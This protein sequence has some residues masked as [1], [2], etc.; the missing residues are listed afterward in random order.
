M[1]ITVIAAAVSIALVGLSAADETRAAIRKPLNIPEQQLGP[2]L[3]AL[4]KDRNLQVLF[5]S[6]LVRDVR[7]AGAIGELTTDEALA[8]LL[9]GTVLTFQYLDEKTITIVPLRDSGPARDDSA[10][11]GAVISRPAGSAPAGARTSSELP[12]AERKPFWERFRL[13]QANDG[14]T[15][16]STAARRDS[17]QEAKELEAITVTGSR[18]RGAVTPS[19]LITIDAQQ[20]REE[21]FTDLG[22][23]IRSVPQNFNGGQNPGVI[24][25]EATNPANSNVT[26]GSSLNLR[27]LGTDATL[28]LLNGQRMSYGGFYPAVD[29]SAIPVEAVERIEIVADGASAIY[30]SD[31]VGGVGNVILKRDFEGVTLNARYGNATDGGA[32]DPRVHRH[33]RHHVVWRR[34]ARDIQR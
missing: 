11:S 13:A 28:T 29:I 17:S 24:D 6:E 18:I 14:T 4:A 30:G 16:S 3:R 27:G 21:G 15:S 26:G 8:R 10:S 25:A 12:G 1:R 5:R 7:T 9:G 20:I 22:E 33:R 2:A 32:D 19:P 34:P 31:A 23:V